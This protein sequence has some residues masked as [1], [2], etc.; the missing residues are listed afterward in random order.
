MT[1]LYVVWFAVFH[2][3]LYQHARV[4]EVNVFIHQPVNNQQT[5]FSETKNM[6]QNTM[7]NC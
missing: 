7:N 6:V 5:I 2:Q 3:G 4:T 1:D